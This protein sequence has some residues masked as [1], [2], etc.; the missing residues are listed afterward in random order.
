MSHRR[1]SLKTDQNILKQAVL[2]HFFPG[3][4]LI[5]RGKFEKLFNLKT[6]AYQG[7]LRD[8][9]VEPVW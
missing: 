4:F 7:F 6:A 1:E 3:S 9:R 2:P 5:F 8:V